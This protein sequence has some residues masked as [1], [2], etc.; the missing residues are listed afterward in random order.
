MLPILNLHLGG[1]GAAYQ[2]TGARTVTSGLS[3]PIAN[4]ILVD[5]L[6]WT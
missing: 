1:F 3:D 2:M 6:D 4:D 5:R